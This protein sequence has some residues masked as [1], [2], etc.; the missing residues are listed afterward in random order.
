MNSIGKRLYEANI[1][2]PKFA[3]AETIR[4]IIEKVSQETN[5]KT[6]ARVRSLRSSQ[7][8]GNSFREI[9][10]QQWNF[11]PPDSIREIEDYALDLYEVTQLALIIVP[12][13]N[14]S[15]LNGTAWL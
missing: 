14:A 4:E 3:G 10:R 11:S 1:G 7:D 8:Q 13:K 2:R 12:D 15:V 9:I 6:H 5:E